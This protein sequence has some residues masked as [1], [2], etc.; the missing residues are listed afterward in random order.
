MV[1]FGLQGY[2]FFLIFALKHSL[3]VLDLCFEQKLEKYHTFSSENNHFY[4]RELL[5]YIVWACYQNGKNTVASSG[6]IPLRVLPISSENCK[7]YSNKN[8]SIIA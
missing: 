8:R 1:K 3:W 2:T 4:S 5:Q 6:V 7:F